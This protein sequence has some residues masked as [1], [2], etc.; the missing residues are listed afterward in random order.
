MPD[1]Q[2]FK[3]PQAGDETA[4]QQG[5]SP[6]TTSPIGPSFDSLADIFTQQLTDA[7]SRQQLGQAR[8]DLVQEAAPQVA[9]NVEAVRDLS[10]RVPG[11]APSAS[12]QAASSLGSAFT[13]SARE[14]AQAAGNEDVV[15]ALNSLLG[16]KQQA[17]AE[18]VTRQKHTA[19]MLETGR[20][21]LDDSG[22]LTPKTE[23]EI[24]LSGLVGEDAVAQVI[25]QGGGDIIR[26]G[27]SKD[28]RFAIAES[29][30]QA[31]GVSEYKKSIPLIELVTVAEQANLDKE[32]DL[33]LSVE[34]AIN[35]FA[36]NTTSTATGFLQQLIPGFA[37]G[38]Q[39]RE[40]R[41]AAE[42]VKAQYVKL[43]S[44]ATV[45]D[46]EMKRLEKFLPGTGKQENIN[47]EDLQKLSRDIKINQA[48]FEKGKRFGLTANQAFA[49]F[50]AETFAEF[51][52]GVEG[53][54]T[55][56]IR[57]KRKS[58]GQLGVL[59]SEEEF[60]SKIYERVK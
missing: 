59:D 46:S 40:M 10:Q 43:I 2:P 55:K 3:Q 29:I 11:E 24:G 42:S 20:F 38:K 23:A 31:G 56:E 44:G 4:R 18:Q 33:L 32:T 12:I 28:E 45:A 19:D 1:Q 35:L 58:D 48:I 6:L 25:K 41:R 51:G 13:T 14:S 37:A 47:L 54:E 21:K 53:A 22:I 57:V 26:R 34:Q 9:Q 17:V 5:A 49:Q 30:L 7:Q 60:D 52:V 8:S 27:K 50:G 39:A 15:R 16:I 36:D